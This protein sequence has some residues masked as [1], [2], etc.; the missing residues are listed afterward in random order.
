[1]TTERIKRRI[2]RLLDQLEEAADSRNWQEV[3]DL[4][5]EVTDLDEENA[6]AL[7]FLRMAERRLGVA[8]A[9]TPT[10]A[11]SDLEA[12]TLVLPTP[13][14]QRETPT[15]FSDG[16]YEVKRFLGEGGKKKSTWP[17]TQ[18]WTVKSRSP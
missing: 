13:P 8:P 1:M 15:S 5:S 2:E 17:T 11:P 6:D 14:A 10:E 3:Y 16:R 12:P 18:P 4:A 7:T 9:P